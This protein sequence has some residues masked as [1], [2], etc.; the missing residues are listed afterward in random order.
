MRGEPANVFLEFFVGPGEFCEGIDE[1][2]KVS[3]NP[4][5]PLRI[6]GS[7]IDE[8]SKACFVKPNKLEIEPTTGTLID[9]RVVITTA[10]EIRVSLIGTLRESAGCTWEVR[11][12]TDRQ[13]FPGFTF[14]RL[15]GTA[16]AQPAPEGTRGC[17]LKATSVQAEVNV[18]DAAG[19][20]Y[21]V[22]LFG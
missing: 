1:A 16:R 18:Y 11:S 19:E 8:E 7:G 3:K 17:T 5:S 12:L 6:N 21:G 20:T 13:E 22:S 9:K 10:G 14:A 15:I 4:F 2:A